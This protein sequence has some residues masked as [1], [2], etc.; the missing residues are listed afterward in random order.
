MQRP[1]QNAKNRIRGGLLF[2]TI[3]LVSLFAIYHQVNQIDNTNLRNFLTDGVQRRN[4]QETETTSASDNDDECGESQLV[5][6]WPVPLDKENWYCLPV[7]LLGLAWMFTGMAIICDEYFVPALEVI[8]ESLEISE[9]V[10]GATLMAAGGSAPE[11]F[12]SFI[13]TFQESDIGFGTI[14]GSAVFNVLFVIG[15]CAIFSQ[16]VLVLTWWPLFRDVCY[17]IFA[18]TM[19]SIVF[20]VTSPDKIYWYEALILFLLYLVYI[21]IMKFNVQI[22]DWLTKLTGQD[23]G[24]P[25]EAVNFNNP[26]TFRA[27]ILHLLIGEKS[28]F[29]TIPYRVITDIQGNLE[30]TFK[31]F[32]KNSDGT[33]DRG[34]FS[35]VFSQLGTQLEKNEI[36]KLFDDLDTDGDG[37]IEFEE[38]SKW[39]VG[40]EQRIEHE[41]KDLFDR[42][43]YNKDG[44]ISTNALI[45]LIKAA[46][47]EDQE[48][49][50]QAEEFL[51]NARGGTKKKRGASTTTKSADDI[52]RLDTAKEMLNEIQAIHLSGQDDVHNPYEGL[53]ILDSGKTAEISDDHVVW[54]DSSKSPIEFDEDIVTLTYN[55][56]K[57]RGLY[58]FRRKIQVIQWFDGD[59][60]EK[61]D[62]EAITFG[63]FR[64]WYTS[65]MF[66]KD[67]IKEAEEEAEH[68]T[69]LG[70]LLHFPLGS[71][72]SGIFWWCF[73][74][75]FM[76]LFY[77]T[78]P[79]VRRYGRGTLKWAIAEFGLSIGWIGVFSVCLVDW[80]TMIGDLFNIPT[81][82]MGVTVLA[83]GTSIPDLL[84]SIIV[85]KRGFGDMAVSSSVGSNIFD[86]LFCL[87]VPWF[88]FAVVNDTHVVVESGNLGISI[89][90]L[91][92]MISSVILVIIY[93]EW[94]MTMTLGYTMFFFY[95]CFLVQ[96]L[97]QEDWSC[98]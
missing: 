18:L 41:M 56:E 79:D 31:K 44:T 90:V 95:F 82:V 43:D 2:T 94:K 69:S 53:W 76:L 83:A 91:I 37:A 87:P 38:F 78:V 48:D 20:Q 27:G 96:H 84:S 46:G 52:G 92:A 75:I 49:I 23:Q 72:A 68:V 65:Q 89:A 21:C 93:N 10:A 57:Y 97:A 70:E 32:D 6:Q 35:D 61:R 67:K 60:W 42:Y 36:D 33:V 1:K 66:Y 98:V 17:Y 14:V 77:F 86:V 39:Y 54:F 8:A 59:V 30:D 58:G 55:K 45:D 81:I 62:N 12:T 40:S 73:S 4:L 13:G 28:I 64:E 15:M 63:V 85:A 26:K 25:I 7:Y 50:E 34:E 80:A 22:H 47:I 24:A 3:L 16:E 19:L 51:S 9:D 74:I 5:V 88:L 11:F 71:G 29:E